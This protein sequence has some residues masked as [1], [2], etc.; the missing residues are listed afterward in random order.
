MGVWK[1]TTK[2]R[3]AIDAVYRI[4]RYIAEHRGK[5]RLL[6]ACVRI[7]R[8]GRS[9]TTVAKWLVAESFAKGLFGNPR[10][11]E[12]AWSSQGLQTALLIGAACPN[13]NLAKLNRELEAAF[14]PA[15]A[16]QDAYMD[17]GIGRES[18]KA[19]QG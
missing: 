1:Y 18:G 16:A 13:P 15:R 7:E 12:F 11:S 3:K 8:R 4:C 17:R 6:D 5:E 14:V 19:V 10:A 2:E 9:D